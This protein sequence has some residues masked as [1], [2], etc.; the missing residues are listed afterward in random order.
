VLLR[1]S[2]FLRRQQSTKSIR[3]W[4]PLVS[5]AGYLFTILSIACWCFILKKGG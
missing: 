1:Y 5:F 4:L 2:G 3:F